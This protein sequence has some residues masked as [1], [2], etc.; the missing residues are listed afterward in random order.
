MVHVEEIVG[1]LEVREGIR[2]AAVRTQVLA[3]FVLV[4]I[5]AHVH[6]GGEYRR[7]GSEGGNREGLRGG[8]EGG[9][10]YFSVPRNSVCS[11][12]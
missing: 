8:K 10:T 6:R 12:K 2:R 1:V 9:E 5:P 7:R 4:G 3:V 11:R